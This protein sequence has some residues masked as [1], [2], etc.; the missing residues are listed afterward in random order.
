MNDISH[1]NKNFRDMRF[2]LYNDYT[3]EG[4]AI[5]RF[6]TSNAPRRVC[7]KVATLGFGSN[8]FKVY[9]V[10]IKFQGKDKEEAKTFMEEHGLHIRTMTPLK[11]DN[12]QQAQ[13]SGRD[14]VK[15]LEE[16]EFYALKE[17]HN[18]YTSYLITVT[19]SSNSQKPKTQELREFYEKKTEKTRNVDKY[20]SVVVKLGVLMI[21]AAKKLSKLD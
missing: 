7:G 19:R 16:V 2:T 3:N 18:F 9:C 1:F 11:E 10:V 12:D 17:K 20:C 15:F 5:F 13:L 21:N 8:L 4:G 14:F 6:R